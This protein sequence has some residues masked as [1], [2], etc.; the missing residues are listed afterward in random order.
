MTALKT[1]LEM[2]Y[3]WESTVPEEVFL[4][5]AEQLQWREYSWQEFSAQVRRL[6]AFILEQGYPEGSRIALLSSNSVDWFVADLAIMLSGHV[7]VPLYPGQDVDSAR[8]ILEHSDCKMIFLGAFN[9]T[10]Q[11]DAMVPESVTRVAIRGNEVRC[12]FQLGDIL[13]AYTPFEGSPI[14]NQDDIFTLLYTSGTT[15]RPKGVMHTHGT[16][17]KVAPRMMALLKQHTG[18]EERGRFFSYLPLSHAAERIIVEMLSLYTNPTVSFSEGLETFAEELRS[19]K[20]TMFFSV[21]RLWCRFKDGVDAAFPPE[22]QAAFGEDEKAFVRS[23]LGLD[24]AK[25]IITGSAPTPRD[26]Q[27]WFIDMGI[28]LRDGYGM[29][30]NFIDGANYSEGIPEPGCVGKSGEG[31]EIKITDDGEICFKSDGLMKGYYKEPEKTAEVLVDGWYHTGDSG[32]I[33]ENGNLWI[34]GRISEVFKTTKGKFV[35]PTELEDSFATLSD[36]GQLLIFGHGYDQPL[37]LANLSEIGKARSK[38]EVTATLEQ[39]LKDI[40]AQ[41][42]KHERVGQIFII[43]DEW[44]IENALLT[45]TMKLKRRS[46]GDHY[47]G[48]VDTHIGKATVV[49]E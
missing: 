4:R 9:N 21:P 40:N 42:P 14:P 30:E 27:Q 44:T 13:D 33:D 47:Q 12:D 45:P 26:V 23:H 43:N 8:Y 16:P 34:T 35:R 28:L 25:V 1:P 29:T 19:V 38:A 5:Q 39:G 2:F 31:V 37:L 32:R 48:W 46:I 15:G 18:D 10:A 36:I 17:A 24:Q 41:L 3:H 22:A 11:V 7:S 20:P 6:A 49:W